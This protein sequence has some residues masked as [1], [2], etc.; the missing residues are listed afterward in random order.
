MSKKLSMLLFVVYRILLVIYLINIGSRRRHPKRKRKLSEEESED[1][2]A[3][4]NTQSQSDATQNN[5]NVY[6]YTYP[7]TYIIGYLNIFDI[8][9][10]IFYAFSQKNTN[11]VHILLEF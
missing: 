5:E 8:N 9:V 4:Q 7:H 6:K 10:Q 2:H 11:N 3:T 1:T